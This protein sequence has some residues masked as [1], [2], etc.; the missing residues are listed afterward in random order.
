MA[1][2]AIG[3][4]IGTAGV[5][6]AELRGKDPATLVRFA[7]LTLPPGAVSA[8]EIA[9]RD[10]VASVLRD[11]WRRGGF[12]SRQVALS[13]ANQS[14]VAR[15]I[16]LPRMGADELRGALRF[17]VQDH[18]PIP[19]EDAVL[20]FIILEEFESEEKQPKMRVLTVAAQREMV[21]GVVDVVGRAGLEPVSIDV[22]PLSLMRA[23]VE[24]TPLTAAGEARAVVDVGAGVTTVVVHVDGTPRFLRILTAGGGDVTAA[25]VADLGMGAEDAEAQ[26]IHLGLGAEGESVDPGAATVI[27]Q[28]ARA[29]IDDVRRSIEY[30]QSQP[31]GSKVAHVTV[32]GGGSR[33][34]RLPERL[35]TALRI[36]VEEGNA[37]A[38]VKV[39]AELGLTDEQLDQVSAVGGVA[40]GSAL[41]S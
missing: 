40:I 41:E 29:F 3:L 16:D 25:L 18:I 20:D 11:L 14:V 9:D 6:A 36:P 13:V 26:K 8:G 7:Q 30:F 5:R 10:A 31:G 37:L 27:E 35:A 34:R 15:Q 38:R 33:M 17:Q 1:R 19:V 22:G 23:L 21:D 2:T 12:K 32:V 4:D 24:S 39:A 28:R